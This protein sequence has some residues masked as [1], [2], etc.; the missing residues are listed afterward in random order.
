MNDPIQ[1]L[2]EARGWVPAKRL[3]MA[4]GLKD[5]R[6]FRGSDSPLRGHVISSDKGYRHFRCATQD[7]IDHFCNR[8]RKHGLGEIIHAR[9]VQRLRKQYGPIVQSELFP[10]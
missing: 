6:A 7:E 3:A 4:C 8:L 2:L 10:A 9:D 1:Y 5:D